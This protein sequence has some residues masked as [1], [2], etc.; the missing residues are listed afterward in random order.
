MSWTEHANDTL[1]MFLE[2]MVAEGALARQLGVNAT[3]SQIVSASR[4]ALYDV[5]RTSIPLARIMDASDLTMHVEGPAVRESTPK[6]S[7]FNV[8]ASTALKSLRMLSAGLFSLLDRDAKTFMRLLD[9]RLT[10]MAPGSLYLGFALAPP[11][12]DLLVGSD[13]PVFESV[14]AAM[15]QLPTVSAFIGKEDISKEI[16]DFLPDPA[17]RD[18][19]IMALF[20]MSPTGR[21]GISS[22]D[23]A[24]PGAKRAQLS[25]RERVILKQA[26]AQPRMNE[27]KHGTF[28]GDLLEIDLSKQRFHVRNV[29]DVGSLRCIAPPSFDVASARKAL[30]EQVRVTGDYETDRQG[31]PRL[32]AVMQIEPIPRAEQP[33]IYSM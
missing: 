29:R 30:G 25:P 7:A 17:Q 8:L 11:D 5:I 3:P 27:R 32:M 16:D 2:N 24:S 19:S 9:L 6:L 1:S 4:E 10:G 22:I 14:R 33:P 15:R 12:E 31:R 20:Q 13:E 21:N 28:V 23:I 26:I 18:N